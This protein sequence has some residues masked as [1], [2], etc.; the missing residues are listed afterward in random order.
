VLT[1]SLALVAGYLA[2]RLIGY[3]PLPVEQAAWRESSNLLLNLPARWDA[4]W[5]LDI[6]RHGYQWQ[7]GTIHQQNIVFFPA[8]PMLV[9]GLGTVLGGQWLWAGLA[10]SLGAFFVALVYLR[11][12]A[13]LEIGE[14]A[15]DRAVWLL[16]GYPFA[17]FFGAVYTES[18]FLL[19]LVAGFW[20]ARRRRW[21]ELAAWGLLLGLTRPNGWWMAPALAW[22]VAAP[23]WQAGIDDGRSP[24]RTMEWIPVGR[25]WLGR[26]SWVGVA[27]ACAPILGVVLYSAY[28]WWAFGHPL[29]WMDGQ[30]A[31]GSLLHPSTPPDPRWGP[32][33]PGR[34]SDAIPI[35]GNISALVLAVVAARPIW[36]RVAPPYAIVVVVTMLP[37]VLAHGIQSLG[38]FTAV[39]FPLFFWLAIGPASSP[40]A[41]WV[42]WFAVGQVVAAMLFFSWRLMV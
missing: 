6:A 42:T 40:T 35:L 38:R 29:A 10:L 31:W 34:V 28:L 24:A 14:A 12:L 9:R 19:A 8:Y 32:P 5:Y 13:T 27:A 15:A 1:R 2:A 39:L 7:D 25:A 16:A 36:R 37:A 30:W 18:L 17:L 23:A 4:Y 41:R 33:R 22:C 3:D 11:R 26:V 20:S 21:L